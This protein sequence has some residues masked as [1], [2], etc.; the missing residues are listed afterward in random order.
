MIYKFSVL[1]ILVRTGLE[2]SLK[3]YHVLEKSLNFRQKSLNIFKSSLN[4]SDFCLKNKCFAQR[5]DWKH[6]NTPLISSV[7]GIVHFTL[8]EVS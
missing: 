5:N 2:K 7:P 3:K 1:Y 4:K 8:F 6:S